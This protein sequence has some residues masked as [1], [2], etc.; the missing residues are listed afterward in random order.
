MGGFSL[1]SGKL[2]AEIFGY[3]FI[4]K[5]KHLKNTGGKNYV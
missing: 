3:E 4:A 2:M 5:R 1:F